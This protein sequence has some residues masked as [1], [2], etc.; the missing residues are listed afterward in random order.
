MKKITVVLLLL[1]LMGL[2]GCGA[3]KNEVVPTEFSKETQKVLQ[4]FQNEAVFFDYTVD[5]SIKAMSLDCWVC[6]DGQWQKNGKSYGNIDKENA[7]KQ[8]ALKLNELSA[9]VFDISDN[10]YVSSKFNLSEELDFK[11]HAWMS[12][13]LSNTIEITPGQEIV[14]WAKLGYLDDETPGT[15]SLQS[16]RDDYCD[17]GIVFTVTFY[18]EEFAE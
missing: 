8:M 17:K 1:S 16:F 12:S 10:G 6:Q 11:D 2:S 3:V 15:F 18:D 13:K 9:E 14:L 7:K 4:I 5:E